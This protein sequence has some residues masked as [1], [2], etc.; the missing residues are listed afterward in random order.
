MS[1]VIKGYVGIFLILLLMMT[2]IG[3]LSA[4]MMVVS[5]QDV[6]ANIIDEL[7]NSAYAK[8][9]LA[10]CFD[11]AGQSGYELSV[12]LFY[13]DGTSC[14]ISSLEEIPADSGNASYARV[15]LKFPL[16]IGFF[17]LEQNHIVSGYAR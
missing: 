4:F 8:D 7:E 1:Q 17:Q 6:H 12:N 9:V 16:T 5:A 14:G 11:T 3:T 10:E 2:S 15:E 13:D